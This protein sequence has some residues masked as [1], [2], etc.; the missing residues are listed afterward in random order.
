[1]QSW[2]LRKIA[3]LQLQSCSDERKERLPWRR[4]PQPKVP[5][6]PDILQVLELSCSGTTPQT[7]NECWTT[8]SW[9]RSDLRRQPCGSQSDDNWAFIEAASEGALG[10]FHCLHKGSLLCRHWVSEL[11]TPMLSMWGSAAVVGL[12]TSPGSIIQVNIEPALVAHNSQ[13]T[14]YTYSRPVRTGPPCYCCIRFIMKY[15]IQVT[16]HTEVLLGFYLFS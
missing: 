13:Y 9:W 7:G 16:I 3:D 6:S 8:D 2:D 12:H 10:F 1:M 4:W 15:C 14:E 5:L 11:P